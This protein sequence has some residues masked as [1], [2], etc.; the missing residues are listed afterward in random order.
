MAVI[1]LYMYCVFRDTVV[2]CH[3]LVSNLRIVNGWTRDIPPLKDVLVI[4]S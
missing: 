3:M 1:T 4:M 2:K